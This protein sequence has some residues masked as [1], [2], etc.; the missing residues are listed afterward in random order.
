MRDFNCNFLDITNHISS[1]FISLLQSYTFRP[2]TLLS[3]KGDFTAA[4]ILDA[5]IT[6]TLKQKY[7]SRVL[8]DN[9]SG[10]FP[11]FTLCKLS[12]HR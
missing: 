10:H 3:Y 11:I 9:T 4:Y 5:I 8:T 7:I 12:I 6:Y 2:L 1:R